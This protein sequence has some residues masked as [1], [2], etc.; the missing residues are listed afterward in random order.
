MEEIT[1]QIYAYVNDL[2]ETGRKI[3]VT[4]DEVPW[5]ADVNALMIFGINKNG[6]SLSAEKMP[7]YL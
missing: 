4:Q 1:S 7:G 3:Q 6:L 5:R 2:K